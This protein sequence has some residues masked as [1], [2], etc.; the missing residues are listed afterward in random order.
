MANLLQS[1]ATKTT[2]VPQFYT[3]YLQNLATKGQQAQ[4]CA[5]YVGAQP[6]QQEAFCQVASNFGVSQPTFQQGISTVGCAANKN[7]LGAAQPFLSAGTSASPL[8]AAKPLICQSA[9]LNLGCLAQCYMSPYISSAVNQMSDI[10]QRNIQQNL[11]P[12]AT[13]AAVGSGQ[14]GSQRGAQVLGQVN[15]NAEQCLNNTIANMENTGYGQALQAAGT[16]QG[17]LSNLAGTTASAQQAQNQA[18]LTAGQTAGTLAGQ[19]AQIKTQ[20]GLGLGTL[21]QESAAQNLSC[22]NALATLGAQCQTIKQNA[23][24]YPLSTLTKLS[25]L[26]Q[27]QQIPTTVTST[28]CMSPLSVAGTIG[29]GILGLFCKPKCGTSLFCNIKTSLGNLGTGSGG[30]FCSYN[31]TT[32]N[33]CGSSYGA[34][35]PVSCV[36]NT[37]GNTSQSYACLLANKQIPMKSGGLIQAKARGGKVGCASLRNLGGLPSRSK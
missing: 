4:A 35:T 18:N 1:S 24:C 20:A 26:M 15:A 14:F 37:Y 23:Q 16:K 30:L 32:Y 36:S 27:G 34:N 9:G 5:Q 17:A 19:C 33:K 21:G 25:G 29:S 2:S 22:I 7:V 28:M 11:D 12:M 8:C 31:N 13:A 3:C 10:A 6:L